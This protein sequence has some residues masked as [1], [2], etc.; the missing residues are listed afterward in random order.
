MRALYGARSGHDVGLY[1]SMGMTPEEIKA[2]VATEPKALGIWPENWDAFRVF[3]KML[4][5]WRVG[6]AGATGMDYGVLPLVM[7]WCEIPEKQ[8]K[9]V[10]NV[11]QQMEGEA[12]SFFSERSKADVH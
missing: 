2:R 7:G 6:M 11:V 12:L 5:Q 1:A 9:R 8:Q 3:E 4:T 10:I